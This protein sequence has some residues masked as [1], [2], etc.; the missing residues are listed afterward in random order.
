M[1]EKTMQQSGFHVEDDDA[2]SE[3][4][5]FISGIRKDKPHLFGNGRTMREFAQHMQAHLANK[6]DGMGIDLKSIYYKES[7]LAP[8]ARRISLQDMQAACRTFELD[9]SGAPKTDVYAEEN[10]FKQSGPE[11][12]ERGRQDKA[13]VYRLRPDK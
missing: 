1:F 8:E 13:K 11:N 6:L 10:P 9:K 2:R 5:E 12:Q 4:W 3:L 7:G